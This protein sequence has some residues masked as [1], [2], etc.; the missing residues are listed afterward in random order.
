V[1]GAA[2]QVAGVERCRCFEGTCR[3]KLLD[4]TLVWNQR[5]LVQ[6]LHEHETH[7][8]CYRAHQWMEQAAPLRAVPAPITDLQR[9]TNIN[10]RRHDRLGGILHEYRYAA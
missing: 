1:A 7:Y 2:A 3:R 9:I 6:V 4:R 8:N 5:H 10:I